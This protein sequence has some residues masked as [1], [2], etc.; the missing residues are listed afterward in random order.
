MSSVQSQRLGFIESCKG[1]CFMQLDM[2][3]SMAAG[4][5]TLEKVRKVLISFQR[6]LSTNDEL[7]REFKT[8]PAGAQSPFKEVERILSGSHERYQFPDQECKSEIILA[9]KQKI[10]EIVVATLKRPQEQIAT[11]VQAPEP[12]AA[13]HKRAAE[14]DI[15][16]K[17]AQQFKKPRPR[18]M[19]NIS[20][21][22]ALEIVQANGLD[23]QKLKEELRKNPLIVKAA[24]TNNP[25]ALEF[26]CKALQKDEEIVTFCLKKNIAALAF[27]DK[28]LKNSLSFVFIFCM[29]LNL[30]KEGLASIERYLEPSTI[31]RLR[32]LYDVLE[33]PGRIASLEYKLLMRTL[34]NFQDG[35]RDLKKLILQVLKKLKTQADIDVFLKEVVHQHMQSFA[36]ACIA[37]HTKAVRFQDL[38]ENFRNDIVLAQEA[39]NQDLS[40][41]QFI[42][43]VLADNREFIKDQIS[44]NSFALNGASD[45][46]KAEEALVLMSVKKHMNGF[47]YAHHSLKFN[48]A[49]VLKVVQLNGW[50]FKYL[51]A[52]MEQDF[53]VAITALRSVPSL[54][55]DLQL[56]SPLF[57][58][59]H[60]KR[61]FFLT[62]VEQ[63]SALI[64]NFFYA[65]PPDADFLL[66]ALERNSGFFQYV[67]KKY[68]DSYDFVLL[69]ALR[70]IK[71]VAHFNTATTQFRYIMGLLIRSYGS[72]M[73][74]SELMQNFSDAKAVA[75][76]EAL[77]RLQK[78]PNEIENLEGD[79]KEERALVLS[80]LLHESFDV[81]K[82]DKTKLSPIFLKLI[83]AYTEISKDPYSLKHF[84][85]CNKLR[86]LIFHA[87]KVAFMKGEDQSAIRGLLAFIDP[88]I[89][90]DASSFISCIY[91]QKALEKIPSSIAN[92]RNLFSIL[93]EK[94]PD[95]FQY[96]ERILKSDRQFI[97]KYLDRYPQLLKHALPFLRN[98]FQFMLDALQK[99]FSCAEY[100]GQGLISQESFLKAALE[101]NLFCILSHPKYS[102][103]EDLILAQIRRNKIAVYFADS[104]LKKNPEFQKKVKEI[105]PEAIRYF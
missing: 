4:V 12:Q 21:E 103:N 2:L 55:Y 104:S 47:A 52:E 14:E 80:A 41:I 19:R 93:I 39:I 92:E 76:I 77:L 50:S 67:P 42:G 73:N 66:D 32:A 97:L 29:D 65:F 70:N 105:D 30:K 22:R 101:K 49:F 56:S 63:G 23:L 102:K 91:D 6:E 54:I 20:E 24:V 10:R 51:P 27:V 90:S 28:K 69:A 35:L 99:C 71:N 8:L 53:D 37:L 33:E 100:V 36:Q 5:E 98:D 74:R 40:A 68:Q 72:Y 86:F 79:S 43:R 1:A 38:P 60:L 88:E 62:L 48:K 31:E 94:N 83:E 18:P 13:S 46:L 82:L 45:R 17:E 34:I 26:A 64:G 61:E 75:F 78:D 81:S 25:L 89:S 59:P 16:A 57:K 3:G 11:P 58:D 7:L 15:E 85:T 9:V 95:N 84:P 87:I 96:A 44:I